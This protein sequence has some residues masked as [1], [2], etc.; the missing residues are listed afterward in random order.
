LPANSPFGTVQQQKKRGIAWITSSVSIVALCLILRFVPSLDDELSGSPGYMEAFAKTTAAQIASVLHNQYPVFVTKDEQLKCGSMKEKEQENV[1]DSDDSLYMLTFSESSRSVCLA[2]YAGV[3]DHSTGATRISPTIG[4]NYGRPLTGPV[5]AVALQRNLT[6]LTPAYIS[7]FHWRTKLSPSGNIAAAK[8]ERFPS[9]SADISFAEISVNLLD[10]RAETAKRHNVINN[11][12]LGTILVGCLVFL[13][14]ASMLHRLYRTCQQYCHA[15]E[16]DLQL[17]EFMMRDVAAIADE[18]QRNY[19]ERQRE[20][21]AQAHVEH[22][23]RLERES[24]R[25]GLTAILERIGDQTIRKSIQEALENNDLPA[26]QSLLDQLSV[27]Q[28][29]QRTPADRLTLLLESL[30]E[31]CTNEQYDRCQAEAFD[32]LSRTGFRDARDIVVARH[33]EFRNV[34]KAL[35]EKQGDFRTAQPSQSRIG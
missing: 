28:A 13:Y 11:S 6:T 14:S 21:Q 17:R 19:S 25:H 30:R 34:F 20:M 15:H 32:L 29:A 4:R 9:R 7:L 27:A 23:A 33:D 18:S 12:L 26:M 5:K 24:I 1:A 31:Y 35:Q 2:I 16:S 8:T 3:S 22:I 10:L